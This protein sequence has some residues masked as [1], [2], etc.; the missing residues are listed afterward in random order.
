M[1]NLFSK[2]FFVHAVKS[3][4]DSMTEMVAQV[5]KRYASPEAMRT[6]SLSGYVPGEIVASLKDYE[7]Q[8]NII[9][10]VPVGN[11][12]FSSFCMLGIWEQ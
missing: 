8:G 3:L 1:V 2:I 6:V 9:Q 4:Q 12:Y 5:G 11:R 10:N 7:E